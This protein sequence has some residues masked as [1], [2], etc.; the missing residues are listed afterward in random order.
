M[1]PLMK[2]P[3]RTA[4]AFMLDLRLRIQ[5][6]DQDAPHRITTKTEREKKKQ[7]LAERRA[8][9]MM[10]GALCPG[11]RATQTERRLSGKDSHHGV[12]RSFGGV[13]RAGHGPAP[14]RDITLAHFS[15]VVTR[16]LQA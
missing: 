12:D 6:R 10:N 2:V 13:T 11:G 15:S 4:I 3:A 14:G 8:A 9:T 7:H 1:M 16:F 5:A